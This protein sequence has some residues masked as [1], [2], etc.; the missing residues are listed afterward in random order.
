MNSY[1][2]N[3]ILRLF[4]NYRGGDTYDLIFIGILRC[5]EHF[6]KN[7]V[8]M[9]PMVGFGCGYFPCVAVA[10]QWVYSAS[11]SVSSVGWALVLVALTQ[12]CLSPLIL[13]LG[14]QGLRKHVRLFISETLQFPL[15][16]LYP[17]NRSYKFRGGR[18]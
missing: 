7:P 4:L 6:G 16:H 15:H 13:L 11:I 3:R 5:V 18:Q 9:L 2:F 8:H 14:L 1:L 17:H 12:Y 10:A